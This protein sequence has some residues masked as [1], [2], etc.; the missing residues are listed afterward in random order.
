MAN[1]LKIILR[2]LGLLATVTGLAIFAWIGYNI[3][4]EWQPQAQGNPVFSSL[5]SLLLVNVGIIW[6]KGKTMQ[7]GKIIIPKIVIIIWFVLGVAYQILR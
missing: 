1:D 5:V 2:L 6:L 4:I 7:D 3:F